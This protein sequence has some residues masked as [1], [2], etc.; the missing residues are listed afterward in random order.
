MRLAFPEFISVNMV[1]ILFGFSILFYLV[2]AVFANQNYIGSDGRSY[3]RMAVN[4]AEGNGF[5]GDIE[6]PYQKMFFREPGFPFFFSIACKI[7]NLLG[8]DNVH[9]PYNEKVESAYLESHPEIVILRILQAILASIIVVLIFLIMT[10][11]LERKWAF[12]IALL[13]VFYLPF[14][15]FITFPQ[16]EIL[17]SFLLTLMGWLFIQSALNERNIIYDL[18]FALSAVFLVLTL[19]AY[20]FI[21]PFFLVSHYFL[22]H[23]W[24]KTLKSA[25]II[26]IVFLMGVAPWILRAYNEV[27]DIRV[28]KSFGTSYTYEFKKYHDTYALAYFLDI[29]GEGEKYKSRIVAGYSEPGRIM[30]EK[31]F[32]G[33]YE[34]KADSL[35]KMIQSKT[36][37]SQWGL[38]KYKLERALKV[39]YR[40]ALLWPLWKTDYR[41][42]ISTLLGGEG[43]IL[44]LGSL[45]LGLVILFFALL[46]ALFSIKKIGVYLPVFIFHFLMIPFMASEGRRVLPFL[47]FYFMFFMIGV[48]KAYNF[49]LRIMKK[50]QQS[51]GVLKAEI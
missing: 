37:L 9:L 6:S 5:S 23:K 3:Q 18:I 11:F 35:N 10:F 25:I 43:R 47:P 22:T 41:K 46:G 12:L 31:S 38:V 4:I 20:V 13:F 7:N 44:M 14:A 40:K 2:L 45:G 33:Y 51:I 24:N 26:S 8:N 36:G 30:F 49:Y 1:K 48:I 32:N 34:T 42:N 50:D 15:I 28:A 17:V 19:Q 16:R 39:N 27:Q 29:D 21:L